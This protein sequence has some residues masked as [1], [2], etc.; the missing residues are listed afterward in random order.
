MRE[1]CSKLRENKV[2][3]T[4][5]QWD[6]GPG[7][8]RIVFMEEGVRDSDR[9]LAICTDAY[10]RKANT[11]E[12]GAG[13]EGYIITAELVEDLGTDKFIPIIRQSS[14]TRKT[15]TFLAPK[16]YI[17]FSD[18][19]QFD[20]SF[21][22]LLREIHDAPLHLKPPLGENPLFNYFTEPELSGRNLLH[23]PK[24][25]EFSPDAYRLVLELARS[26]DA[27]GWSQLV[28]RIRPNIFRAL[29]SWRQEELDGQRAEN[30]EQR[31]QVVDKA[32]DIVSPL[33]S[34]ALGGIK[35]GNER[36]SD[37]GSL[38]DDL[39][40]IQSME[41]WK[42]VGYMPW[43]EIPYALGYIYHNLH[44]SLCL[45]INRLDLAFSLAQ[46]KFPSSINSQFTRS[47]WE[48]YKLMGSYE[49]LG[50]YRESWEYLANAFERWEWLSLI[51]KN[52]QEY[53]IAL[54]A[55]HMALGI[56]ELATVIASEKQ[57]ELD[58]Y[59]TK[60]GFYFLTE[61]C[62]IKQRAPS[63][64]VHNSELSELWTCIGIRGRQMKSSWEDWIKLHESSYWNY[65][66]TENPPEFVNFFDSVY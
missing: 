29:V 57:K 56:H 64:L 9:V 15:P 61:K 63:L 40:N 17:D 59:N 41:G 26:G 44:G 43:I 1:F 2:D 51:F 25:N 16:V 4:L 38:L 47:V 45:H 34:M 60:V 35:S 20:T 37:Q 46:A 23:I 52:D 13:Y 42:R 65:D 10:V 11:R 33:I 18:D 66:S 49:S 27:S 14:D 6:L 8:D 39:L 54:V 28:E 22:Q 7:D 5:D 36:F 55:Y 32:V 53:R 3:V 31:H 48:N 58:E 50:G 62:E 30:T 21:E 19:D 12:K 24:K